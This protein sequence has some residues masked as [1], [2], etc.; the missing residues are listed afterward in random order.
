MTTYTPDKWVILA[1]TQP[2]GN[3][4]HKV[5]ATW[6]GG[7]LEGSSWKLNSGNV[8]AIKIG[9]IYSVVGYSESVYN[10]RPASY[11]YSLYSLGVLTQFLKEDNVKLLSE[12]ESLAYLESQIVKDN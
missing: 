5:F 7:Y 11:G 6:V 12:S 9:N 3:V 1:I 2:D 4:L 10:L 8:S